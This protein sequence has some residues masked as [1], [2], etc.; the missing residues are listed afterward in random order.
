MIGMKRAGHKGK[1]IASRRREREERLRASKDCS[2][3]G[4]KVTISELNH[5]LILLECKL[6]L[7]FLNL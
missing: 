5:A 4:L 6:S 1:V 7:F 2:T 3:I